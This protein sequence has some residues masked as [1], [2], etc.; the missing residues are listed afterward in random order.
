[1]LSPVYVVSTYAAGCLVRLLTLRIDNNPRISRAQLKAVAPELLQ[2]LFAVLERA[3]SH[4][5]EYTMKGKFH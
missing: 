1:V 4:E 5:N 3:D 2:N